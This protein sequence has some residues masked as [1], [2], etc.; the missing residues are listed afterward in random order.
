MAA[1][2]HIAPE[3]LQRGWFLAAAAAVGNAVAGVQNGDFVV[4]AAARRVQ[5]GDF[6]A[7]ASE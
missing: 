5:H 7:A 4:A 1:D 3:V 2:A 6:V